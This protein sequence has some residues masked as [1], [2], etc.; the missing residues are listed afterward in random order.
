MRQNG[1]KRNHFFCFSPHTF[2]FF[3]F[4]TQRIHMSKRKTPLSAFDDDAIVKRYA[5]RGN[6]KEWLRRL[7]QEAFTT[8]L[9]VERIL[10]CCATAQ[11]FGSLARVNALSRALAAP[12]TRLCKEAKVAF[13]TVHVTSHTSCESIRYTRLPNGWLHGP[14]VIFYVGN[15]NVSNECQWV[16]NKKHGYEKSYYYS[17]EPHS[18]HYWING[19]KHGKQTEYNFDGKPSNEA[20][21]VDGKQHGIEKTWN[22]S[23]TSW[24]MK[25]WR[26]GVLHGTE[27]HF[28]T[29]ATYSYMTRVQ[30][31]NNG[32]QHGICRE[33]FM[34]CQLSYESNWVDG[35]EH[36]IQRSWYW[37]GARRHECR[38]VNGN[39]E[40]E[41]RHWHENGILRQVCNYAD[42]YLHGVMQEW[43][44]S[45]VLYKKRHYTNNHKDGLA[46]KRITWYT[47]Q[48]IVTVWE[49]GIKLRSYRSSANALG[50]EWQ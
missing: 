40:G 3:S 10:R 30:N 22:E 6:C 26:N 12:G 18:E 27:K 15:G 44:A 42:G 38:Y 39:R 31:W 16:D 33:W 21:W 35:R 5:T 47:N 11:D 14:R 25:Y 50:A 49:R 19:K 23:Y 13:A 46:Y 28:T 9:I 34:N 43:D 37:Y 7:H 4:T 1:K 48:V 2:Y 20:Y 17:G 29:T 24:C 41:L 45:G 32:K 36:G 8:P